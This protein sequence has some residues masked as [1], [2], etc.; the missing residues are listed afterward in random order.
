VIRRFSGRLAVAAVM[1][2]LGFLA[3]TQLRS[4]TTDNALSDLSTQDLTS[5]IANVT[6]RNIALRDEIATLQAQKD[7]VASSVQRGDTSTLQ[8]RTDLSRVE[9]WSGELG[10]TGPGVRIEVQGTLPGVAVEVLL[11]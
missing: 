4:Q 3:V 7:S 9:G 11:N 2:L 5:L 10:V 1:L 8:I 6:A